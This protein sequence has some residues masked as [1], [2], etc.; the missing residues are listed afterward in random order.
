MSSGINGQSLIGRGAPESGKKH[1]VA[2]ATTRLG[3]AGL[4]G[5]CPTSSAY[6][7]VHRSGPSSFVDFQRKVG[8]GIALCEAAQA[9]DIDC[10]VAVCR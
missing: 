9:Y 1:N 2:E 5:R 3:G 4:G 6:D 10:G 8:G 7:A